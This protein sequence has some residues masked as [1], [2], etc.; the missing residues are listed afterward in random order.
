MPEAAVYVAYQTIVQ[1]FFMGLLFLVSGYF[2]PPSY[3]RKGAKRFLSDRLIRLGIPLLIFAAFIG[4]GVDYVI[5][6]SRGTFHRSFLAYLPH[7]VIHNGGPELG[8]LWFVLALLFFAGAYLAWRSFSPEPV[9]ARPFPSNRVILAFALLLGAVTFAVRIAF[10]VGWSFSLFGFQVAYFPQ[11]IALFIVGLIAF[12]SNWLMTVPKQTGRLWSK[13]AWALV[14]VMF[15]IF[16]MGLLTGGLNSFLGGF[17]WQ[18]AAYALWEQLFGVAVVIGLTVWFRERLNFQNRLTK[19]LSDSSYAAYILQFPVL[20]F[21][22]MSLQSVHLPLL[23]KFAAVSPIGVALCFL[24][25]Y[26]V[27]RI[28]KADRVL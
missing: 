8:P 23:L 16:V 27:R 5:D 7:S 25:G 24:V 11:Y 21:L 10:P 13:V 28:P 12:R 19:A 6:L 2:T 18:A 22:A 15:L 9:R 4:P 17:T 1:A 14:P 26:S 3:D 20:T